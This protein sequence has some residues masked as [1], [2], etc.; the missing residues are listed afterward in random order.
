MN[1]QR[2]TDWHLV[3]TFG[4]N[5]PSTLG[6]WPKVRASVQ[7][8]V[9]TREFDRDSAELCADSV[10]GRTAQRAAEPE[11]DPEAMEG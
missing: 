6:R 9:R 7:G 10:F 8:A 11:R 2:W 1:P 5:R 3:D 4:A